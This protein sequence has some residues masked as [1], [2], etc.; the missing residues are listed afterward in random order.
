MPGKPVADLEIDEALVHLLLREQHADLAHLPLAHVDGGWDNELFRLGDELVVRLPRRE[1]AAQLI[2]HEQRWLPQLAARL[3]IPASVPL[4]AGTPSTL[5]PWSWTI[6]RWISGT[7]ADLVEP[8]VDQATSFANFLRALH[9]PAPAE[10]LSN[11]LRGVPL[12]ERDER[13]R[14]RIEHLMRSAA[15][16]R[17]APS[18]RRVW[19]EALAAPA[20]F[21]RRWLHGDLHPLNVLVSS[22]SDRRIVGII[23]WGDLAG[24]DVATDLASVWMLFAD[25]ATRAHVRG[26]YGECDDAMWTRAKGW[27]VF[28]GVVLLDTG[29]MNSPRHAAVGE[30]IL[31]NVLE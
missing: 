28:F 7:P 16:T 12:H 29:L 30:R 31:N 4:R 11:P 17:I 1:A 19:D 13:V 9:V 21:E 2:E 10:A 22:R 26:A 18:V 24:G 25:P 27:A 8:D 15:F 3:P 6:T 14:A 5:F 20:S 23:D